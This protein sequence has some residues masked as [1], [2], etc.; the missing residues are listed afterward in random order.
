LAS[1]ERPFIGPA[2]RAFE[3]SGA[4]V[5]VVLESALI[6][7]PRFGIATHA[8]QAAL[9]EQPFIDAACGIAEP[10]L[11]VE[12]SLFEFT[13]VAITACPLPDPG[14]MPLPILERATVVIA[15][16]VIDPPFALQKAVDDLAPITTAIRQYGIGGKQWLGVSASG[17]QTGEK[18]RDEVAHAVIRNSEARS[19]P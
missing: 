16:R 13:L 9:L 7:Q 4:V 19:M 5:E 6:A 12:Q 3:L 2:V 11:A 10:P 15:V 17:Q 14:T 8:V 18:S 1:D